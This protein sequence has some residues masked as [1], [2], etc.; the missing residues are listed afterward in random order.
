MRNTFTIHK[1]DK[2]A[3]KRK[4]TD[5]SPHDEEQKE[6]VAITRKLSD[7]ILRHL[8]HKFSQDNNAH[9]DKV[10]RS[11][12]DDNHVLIMSEFDKDKLKIYHVWNPDDVN[13]VISADHDGKLGLTDTQHRNYEFLFR[14][15]NE[16]LVMLW[17]VRLSLL[18]LLVNNWIV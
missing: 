14:L 7:G 11:S 8:D 13:A 2:T 9:S 4:G 16:F 3:K 18:T 5:Q 17:I 15:Y 10:E 12:K 1:S 6:L